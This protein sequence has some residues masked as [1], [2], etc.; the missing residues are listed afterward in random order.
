MDPIDS[1]II[2]RLSADGRISWR[3]LG[4][5]VGLSANAVADRVR[6]LQRDGVISGFSATLDPAAAGRGLAALVDARLAPATTAERFEGAI[7]K[8]DAVVEAAHVNG[9]FDYHLRVACRDAADLDA[10]LRALKRDAG[11]VDTETRIVLRGVVQRQ[12]AP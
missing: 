10:T 12:P 3:D 4:G 1:E 7:A 8:L 2:S 9:R 5:Q 6:R 11:V